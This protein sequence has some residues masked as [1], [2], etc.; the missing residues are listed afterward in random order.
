MPRKFTKFSYKGANFRI[1]CQNTNT[2]IENIISLRDSLET[3]IARH[4]DF[5]KSLVPL[6]IDPD[7]LPTAVAMCAAAKITGVG[8]MAAVAGVIA[9]FSC[10]QALSSGE[11]IREAIVDNGGD[12]YFVSPEAVKI[13]IYAGDNPISGRLAFLIQPDM[14]PLSVCSSSSRMGHS[15]SF[16]D[17]DLVT[18]FSFSGA[19]ADAAATAVCNHIKS[20]ADI[21]PVINDYSDIDGISGIF[22]VRDD[23]IGIAGTVPEIIKLHG[24]AIVDKITVDSASGD[25][26]KIMRHY[27]S[28]L[29]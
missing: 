12:G 26:D 21:Q 25:Y 1:C 11:G 7:E 3:Y 13:G 9:Q 28:L 5:E 6:D 8:P 15:L 18:I 2:I 29:L 16:G 4:P 22:A 20:A 14:M 10:E 27:H 17:C 24:S 19:L 23:K